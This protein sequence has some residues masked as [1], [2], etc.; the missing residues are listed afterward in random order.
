MA[1]HPEELARYALDKG[2]FDVVLEASGNAQA[3]HSAFEVLRPRGI[4]VQMGLAGGEQS[5]ALNTLVAKEFDL[6]GTFR[7]HEEFG[8]AVQLIN[9]GLVDLKPLISA[10]LPYRDASRAFTLAADRTQ[11][12]KVLLNFD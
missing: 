4:F 11:S 9:Q 3:L 5:L 7:F 6:R 2:Q 1:Q 10:T 12:M 8:V